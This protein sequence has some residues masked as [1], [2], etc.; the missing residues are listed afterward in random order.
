MFTPWGKADTVQKIAD[1]ITLVDTPSHGGFHIAKH[2]QG[3]IPK[4]ARDNRFNPGTP[5][6][7]ED[8]EAYIVMVAFPEVATFLGVERSHALERLR[9]WYPEAAAAFDGN[10]APTR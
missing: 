4:A 1:G 7:E 8:C 9:A 10:T 3:E 2:R 6:Y 5:W